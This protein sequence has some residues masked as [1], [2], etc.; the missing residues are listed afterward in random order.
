M[1]RN[2]NNVNSSYIAQL[3]T[4]INS[5]KT[6]N[7]DE[8]LLRD[9]DTISMKLHNNQY[10]E[11]LTCYVVHTKSSFKTKQLYKKIFFWCSIGILVSIV[12]LLIFTTIVCIFRKFDTSV[13]SILVPVATSFLTVFI[14]I[15]QIIT[16]YLF[17]EMEEENISKMV[18]NIQQMD[19]EI[20]KNIFSNNLLAS[21]NKEMSD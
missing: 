4:N 1:H 6:I 16:K 8:E 19:R 7:S 9:S 10:D 17:N 11:L 15:P 18:G 2:A 5:Y 3:L 12:I 20:R 21:N 13:I 14:V